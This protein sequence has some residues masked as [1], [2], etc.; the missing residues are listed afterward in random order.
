MSLTGQAA[1]DYV[2]QRFG[3][4]PAP[5]PGNPLLG[6]VDG[7]PEMMALAQPSGRPTPP[8]PLAPS[9]VVSAPPDTTKFDPN[10]VFTRIKKEREGFQAEAAKH[11]E[12]YEA[13]KE[14]MS[15]AAP[16]PKETPMEQ[17]WGSA[18]MA[19][20]ALGGFLTRSHATTAL[21]SMAGVMKAYHE[22]DMQRYQQQYAQWK[23]QHDTLIKSATMEA[24]AYE[25]ALKLAATK[26]DEARAMLTA[27]TAAYR[28]DLANMYFNTGQTEAGLQVLSGFVRGA[29]TLKATGEAT[30][31]LNSALQEDQEAFPTSQIGAV[32]RHRRDVLIRK[33]QNP[34]TLVTKSPT[35][36]DRD[37]AIGKQAAAAAGVD[38]NDPAAVAPFINKAEQ[39]RIKGDTA[40]R[41]DAKPMSDA[42][43]YATQARAAVAAKGI[44]PGDPGYDL[45]YAD[46]RLEA[47][48]NQ[49]TATTEG[50]A[51]AR[52]KAQPVIT[53]EGA[54]IAVDRLAKGD[55]TAMVGLARNTASIIKVDNLLAKRV[56]EG[57]LTVDQMI[58]A[59]VAL[60]AARKEAGAAATRL[61]AIEISGEEAKKVAKEV[62]TTYAK[63]D[64]GDFRP[65][66]K[67]RLMVETNTSNPDQKAAYAADFA[68]TTAY[69][70]ALNPQGVPREGDI[71]HAQEM[72][73]QTDS[74][75]GHDA[76]VNQMLR[77]LSL[78]ESA[79]GEVRDKIIADIMKRP[80][81]N[82]PVSGEPLVVTDQEAWKGLPPG[83]HWRKPGDPAGQYRIKE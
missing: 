61:A 46:A 79:T 17:Q 50:N 41:Q 18:A 64:R 71:K 26:P 63:L 27:Q 43:A 55:R 1:D 6:G 58:A 25:A 30:T 19:V 13:A 35:A 48:R 23:A 44:K 38:V 40:A 42:E 36:N 80:V 69:A 54:E 34:N 37:T 8:P 5:V 20:A 11:L 28:Q 60:D 3:N 2:R 52:Q 65:F 33:G 70:R 9:P 62:T 68:L 32:E 39:D 4:P 14:E 21:N 22:G 57:K 29:A 53:D 67:L 72:L 16:P 15:K 12:A 74:I 59:G 77:E 45:A 47:E 49:K 83:A 78:I 66:N 75:G 81:M 10:E 51:E 73:S 7:Q 82:T 24:H 76:V 56:H 31:S